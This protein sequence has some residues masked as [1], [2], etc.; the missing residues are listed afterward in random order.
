MFTYKR[1]SGCGC[2]KAYSV[3]DIVHLLWL[4]FILNICPL[5]ASKYMSLPQLLFLPQAFVCWV[6]YSRQSLA[7]GIYIAPHKHRDFVTCFPCRSTIYASLRKLPHP[8]LLLVFLLLSEIARSW[9][10]AARLPLRKPS[11]K[12]NYYP[13]FRSR[14]WVFGAPTSPLS[15]HLLTKNLHFWLSRPVWARSDFFF[16]QTKPPHIVYLK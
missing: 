3:F 6:H 2:I 8:S 14:C 1:K 4:V 5:L 15:Y 10:L 9:I 12:N 7:E 16:V 13:P 11:V